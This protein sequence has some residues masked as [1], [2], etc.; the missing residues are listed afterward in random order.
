MEAG[1]K[2]SSAGCHT[3]WRGLESHLFG[4]FVKTQGIL[5]AQVVNSQFLKVKDISI[6][7]VKVSN[8]F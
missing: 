8:F 1:L 7:A 5:F 6:F 2:G 4:K 3:R